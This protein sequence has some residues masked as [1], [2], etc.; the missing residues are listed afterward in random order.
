MGQLSFSERRDRLSNRLAELARK[1][2]NPTEENIRC[3]RDELSRLA[4]S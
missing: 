3:V 1:L 4:Q 2:S